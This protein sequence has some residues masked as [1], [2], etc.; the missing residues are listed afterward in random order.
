MGNKTLHKLS[1]PYEKFDTPW[2]ALF[3]VCYIDTNDCNS[4][5][6]EDLDVLTEYRPYPADFLMTDH[7]DQNPNP[8][9][10]ANEEPPSIEYQ[11]PLAL[12]NEQP[13]IEYVGLYL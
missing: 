3:Q 10:I 13:A 11:R 7:T 9:K 5:A 2:L 1:K 12:T 4:G 6:F 8:Q